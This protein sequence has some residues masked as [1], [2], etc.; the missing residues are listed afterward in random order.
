MK[1][2]KYPSN[3]AN[4]QPLRLVYS[5]PSFENNKDDIVFGVSMYQI[6]KDYIPK[7]VSIEQQNI[8]K[9]K[10]DK[11]SNNTKANSE[12]MIKADMT[13]ST[14]IAILETTQGNIT[15][16]FFPKAAPKHVENFIKFSKSGFYDG[17]VFHRIVKDFVIQARRS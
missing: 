16:E 14:N 3:G 15:L 1:D 2:V 9:N 5:S 8:A 11:E 6:N 7:P 13:P 10:V 4:D 12:D 17:V